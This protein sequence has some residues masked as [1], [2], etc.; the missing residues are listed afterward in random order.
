MSLRGFV[1]RYEVVFIG[2]CIWLESVRTGMIG[3]WALCGKGGNGVV[4]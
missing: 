3:A 1:T 2:C 4:V